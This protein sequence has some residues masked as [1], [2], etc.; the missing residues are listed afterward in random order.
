[1]RHTR[2]SLRIAIRGNSEWQEHRPA[3]CPAERAGR[4]PGALD[5]MFVPLACGRGV[6]GEAAT[7]RT[8]HLAAP[9][10][11]REWLDHLNPF[12]GGPTEK[13]AAAGVSP[14]LSSRRR[15]RDERCEWPDSRLFHQFALQNGNREQIAAIYIY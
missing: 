7:G 9:T 11:P 1:V 12:G 5:W 3:T 6:N 13:S 2:Q 8:V 4:T 14:H 10:Q 15:Y